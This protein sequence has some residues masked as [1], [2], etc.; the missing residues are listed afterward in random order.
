MIGQWGCQTRSLL[1]LI[2]AGA[3]K[4]A[5]I[6]LIVVL[7]ASAIAILLVGDMV[8]DL[9]VTRSVG[10]VGSKVTGTDLTLDGANMFLFSG[11][12]AIKNLGVG[13]PAGYSQLSA[14]QVGTIN[15]GLKPGSVFSDTLQISHIRVCSPQINFEGNVD[16]NNLAALLQNVEM[17]LG[18]NQSGPP[19]EPLGKRLHVDDLLITGAKVN[20]PAS[21]LGGPPQILD[22][23]DIHLTDLGNASNSLSSAELTQ[24]VLSRLSK[25]AI[26]A[27]VE[28]LTNLTSHPAPDSLGTTLPDVK[29]VSA[30]ASN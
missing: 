6:H 26:A 14:I 23:P 8:L 27:V 22:L 30:P 19:T 11:A 4:K 1:L 18:S 10:S 5:V 2:N 15:V 12:G 16:T 24:L 9:V 3:M 17:A 25:E 7:G 21:V 13:N 20:L 28:G 29:P